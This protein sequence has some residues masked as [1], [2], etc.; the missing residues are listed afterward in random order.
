VDDFRKPRMLLASRSTADRLDKTNISVEK[1][2]A[3]NA[4]SHH[5]SSAKQENVHRHSPKTLRAATF[6]RV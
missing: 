5:T 3:E 2:L 1:T 6:S 4:L